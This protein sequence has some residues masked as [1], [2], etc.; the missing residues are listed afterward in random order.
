M[1]VNPGF[2]L[3]GEQRAAERGEH[4]LGLGHIGYRGIRRVDDRVHSAQQ[5]RETFAR[6]QVDPLAAAERQRI[7]APTPGLLDDQSPD[8]ARSSC[9]RDAHAHSFNHGYCVSTI[10]RP[11]TMGK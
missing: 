5:R 1:V 2:V 3:G 11:D 10:G 9:D 4:P 8:P 6:G 7:V